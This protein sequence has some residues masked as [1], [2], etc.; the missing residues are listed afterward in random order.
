MPHFS[1]GFEP[2]QSNLTKRDTALIIGAGVSGCGV[3]IALAKRG[4]RCKLFDKHDH[5]ANATSAVPVAINQPY[6]SRNDHLSRRY[7]LRAF[8]RSLE[9][10]SQLPRSN[11]HQQIGVLKLINDVTDWQPTEHWKVLSQ[12]EAEEMAHTELNS[13]A[14]HLAGGGSVNLQA[15]CATRLSGLSNVEFHGGTS[16]TSLRKTDLGWQLLTDTGQVADESRLV[17][18]AN[19][20]NLTDFSL[21]DHLPL[22]CV[23]GQISFFPTRSETRAP[24]LIVSGKGYVIPS[25]TGYWAGATHQR[26]IA[27]K[28]TTEQDDQANRKTALSLCPQLDIPQHPLHSWAGTRCATPDRLP[29]VGA[30]PDREFYQSAYA[31]LHHGRARQLY[32]KAAYEPGLFAM[33]GFGS[34]A[35]TQM[36]YA[37]EHLVDIITQESPSAETY[38][39][40]HPARFLMRDLRRRPDDR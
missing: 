34:R 23:G 3:A 16:I 15:F 25:E 37:A 32:P 6:I 7:F 27:R 26:E 31:D 28:Q 39:L 29:I 33:V 21:C 9:E 1:P 4:F 19:S 20:N 30:L 38:K 22:Q 36:I 18:M 12:K 10:F 14:L 24:S 8:D 5:I 13:G 11:I 17:I 2:P 40:L 35:A